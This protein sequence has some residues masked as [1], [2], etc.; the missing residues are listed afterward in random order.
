VTRFARRAAVGVGLALAIAFS[1]GAQVPMYGP[2]G[3]FWGYP[4][5]YGGPCAAP[6]DP[7]ELRREVRRELQQQEA[8]SA[9]P[10]VKPETRSPPP[11]TRV[12]EIRPEFESASQIREEFRRSGERR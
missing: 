4:Y 11:P 12:E 10:T 8:T 1:A 3:P 5:L 6:C 9:A 2:G 7:R